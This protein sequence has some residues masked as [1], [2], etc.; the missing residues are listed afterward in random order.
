MTVN[1]Q[2]RFRCGLPSMA[3]D[4][5]RLRGSWDEQGRPSNEWTSVP[6]QRSRD[7]D[8][9]DVFVIRVP[10]PDDEIGTHFRWGIELDRPG[11]SSL[12][13]I[14]AEL[15][16][17]ASTRRE[18]SFDLQQG[19]APQTYY[20][21]W[22]GRLGANRV[23]RR[24]G[25]DGIRISVWAPNAR[26]VLLVL[27]DPAVGYIADDGTGALATIGMRRTVDEF[28]SVETGDDDSLSDF[29]SMVGTAYMY[30]ITKDDGSLAYRTDIWSLMQI[31][32]GDFDPD[33][34]A[35]H[36]SPAA[37]DGP[38]SCSVVCDLKRV[39][40]PSGQEL[41]A[42]AFWADEFVGGRKLPDRLE[43]LV[44]YE[45]HVGALG[46]GKAAPGTL[47][48]AV[49]FVEHLS[50]LGVN[51]VEL[52][53]IAEFETRANWGYG[54]S[55]F[56]A[57]DQG[58]GGTDRLKIF[59]KACH[60]RGIAVILD[61]CY[62]HFD[63]DGERA[64]WAY[65]SNDHTRNIYYWY[66]G[67]PGDYA[68]PT[69]GYIDN[70]STGWAPRFHEEA[71]RQLFISSAAFLVSV[72]HIDGF[73]LD[74]TSSIHQYP[75][76]HADGRRADRA[77]AFGAKFLKQWT[78]TMRLI[79][80]QLFLTAEDYS[81]WSAMTEPSLTGDGLGFD[82]TWYGDFHH[83]LVEYHGGAQAQLLKN[84]GFGDKRALTMS[85]LASALQT[86]AHSKV[87][88]NQS[89]DDCGNREG[90]ARTAVIAVNFAPVVGETKAWAEA[91]SR[92]AAAMTL[93]SPGTPMFFMGEEIGARKPY[94][95]ND[96]LENRE[97]ILGEAEGRGA[98]MLSCYRDLIALSI[99][100]D[101][102]RSRNIATPLVHDENRVIAFHRWNDGEDFLVV[103]SLN[104]AP[105]EHGYRLYS[106]RLGDGLW[107]EIF[108][109]D[110][111]KY[112]GWNVGNGGGK[113][114]ATAGV[115]NAVLPA[116]GVLVFRRL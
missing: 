76:L 115:L 3:F 64:Q 114:R 72:C 86:S 74:Q 88:Y 99:R 39:V 100:Q 61:V 31:G 73:R 98:G 106:E 5:V 9:Y 81:D 46:F 66:A 12:W 16:D 53:P 83:N 77:A 36:G 42:E 62:N 79:K 27:A 11:A 26:D 107:E 21:T 41:A 87:V 69:G 19:I 101:A 51:A 54:T 18:R 75:V 45:L 57:A 94:R 65:D 104:D 35:Y 29:D 82:A 47:D 80:P 24:D 15:D 8:G 32:A 58:A 14:A 63:P 60:Q 85:S 111:D 20:L 6:M 23:E 13:A 59:V 84:A 10:F 67:R 37:L 78:R 50:A 4:N 89:H 38:Q 93:L 71:V 22:I 52:L 2:F 110:A 48:D 55:H 56:F 70:I 25:V 109:T 34:A 90:S 44:I 7:E 40:L 28:W 112:G 92:F 17:E 103:G 33:G 95:Y 102:I 116:S 97:N 91:R 108:N 43:D 113:I 68:D 30:R 1:V 49:A 105:F 96:F